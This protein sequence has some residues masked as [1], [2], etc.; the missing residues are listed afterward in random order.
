MALSW[1]PFAKIRSVGLFLS[2]GDSNKSKLCLEAIPAARMSVC[3]P[4]A[5]PV[6][7]IRP[8]C[9]CEANCMSH[10]CRVLPRNADSEAIFACYSWNDFLTISMCSMVGA[11]TSFC[12]YCVL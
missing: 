9:T 1:S 2:S 5:E 7:D 4:Q 3:H 11:F 10:Q 6:T 8:C 12:V